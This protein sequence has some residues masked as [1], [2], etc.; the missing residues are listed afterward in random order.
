MYAR[1]RL[2]GHT[3]RLNENTPARQAML[4]YFQRGHDDGRQ[5]NFVH[6]ATCLSRE[7]KSVTDQSI[8][9]SKDYRSIQSFATDR[10]AWKELTSD[11]VNK[12]KE[13]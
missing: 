13:Q 7:Y 1:W 2:F 11:V 9:T 5:G 6:I 8:T 10:D 12:Y 4:Y 3:L